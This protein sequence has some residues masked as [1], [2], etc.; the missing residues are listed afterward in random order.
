MSWLPSDGLLETLGKGKRWATIRAFGIVAFGF[1]LWL[2]T[3]HFPKI[4]F[5]PAIILGGIMIVSGIVSLLRRDYINRD[6][7]E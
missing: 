1:T 7:E 4:V 6:T 3:P 2:L 5:W